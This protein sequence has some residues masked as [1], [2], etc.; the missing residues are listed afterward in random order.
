[1]TVI[2]ELNYYFGVDTASRN[3]SYRFAWQ[4][5]RDPPFWRGGDAGTQFLST[6]ILPQKHLIDIKNMMCTICDNLPVIST[7]FQRSDIT[8]S[9]ENWYKLKFPKK[10]SRNS[11][12]LTYFNEFAASIVYP[13]F[14]YA[15]AD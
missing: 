4:H 13:M 15:A 5:A 10:S 7:M 8:F 3:T 11:H 6:Q 12:H 9:V 14:R 1:M 2:H